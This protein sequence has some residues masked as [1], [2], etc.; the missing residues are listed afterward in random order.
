MKV[1]ERI[2]D[3]GRP[4]AGRYWIEEVLGRGGMGAVYRVRDARND[5][6]LALKRGYARDARK[7][8]KR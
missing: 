5:K 1:P 4:I 6:R 8:E 7:T 3:T 2:E